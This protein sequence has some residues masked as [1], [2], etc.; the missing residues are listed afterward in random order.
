MPRNRLTY[1][2]QLRGI[3]DAIVNPCFYTAK[4]VSSH[5]QNG[6]REA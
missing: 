5:H 3:C 2:V 4:D 1:A 6:M